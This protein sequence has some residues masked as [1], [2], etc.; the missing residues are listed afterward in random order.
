[1][2]AEFLSQDAPTCAVAA[3][4]GARST[5]ASAIEDSVFSKPAEQVDVER[6]YMIRRDLLRIRN[7]VARQEDQI[8]P[9]TR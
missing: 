3:R 6:L 7:A 5:P 8:T 9:K 4:N 1:M 2:G